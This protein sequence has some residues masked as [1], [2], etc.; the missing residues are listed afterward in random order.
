MLPPGAMPI[1][2]WRLILIGSMLLVFKNSVV[3]E[4]LSGSPSTVLISM[5]FMRTSTPQSVLRRAA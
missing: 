2:S 1:F 4:R 3:Q 5:G